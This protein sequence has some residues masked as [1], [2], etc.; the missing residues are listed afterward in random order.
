MLFALVLTVSYIH[1]EYREMFGVHWCKPRALEP[2]P[3][4]HPV[5]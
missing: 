3:G 4:I 1:M 5:G 2:W